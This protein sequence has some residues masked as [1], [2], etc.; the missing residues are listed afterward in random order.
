MGGDYKVVVMLVVAVVGFCGV[1]VVV[2]VTVFG[3][4]AFVI[5]VE[6]L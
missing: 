3:R 5:V 4:M 6:V 2:L 1:V